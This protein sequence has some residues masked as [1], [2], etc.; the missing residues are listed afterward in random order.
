[1]Y[2]AIK[3][4]FFALTLCLICGTLLAVASKGLKSRQQENMMTDRR[5]NILKSVWFVNDEKKYT[6]DEIS[7]LYAENIKQVN[8]SESGMIIPD[9][10][11]TKIP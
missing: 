1:M 8:V 9:T 3:S 2:N 7:T 5:K 6:P 4:I 11:N 10:M